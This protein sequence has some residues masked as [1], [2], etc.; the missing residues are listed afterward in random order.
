MGQRPSQGP[1]RVRTQTHGSSRALECLGR[2]LQAGGWEPFTVRCGNCPPKG[3]L[4]TGGAA[5]RGVGFLESPEAAGR[6][7]SQPIL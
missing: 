1:I 2:L 7:I 5:A 3:R 6:F 4:A